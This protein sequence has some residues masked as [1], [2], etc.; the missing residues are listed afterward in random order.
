MFSK[1]IDVAIVYILVCKQNIKSALLYFY[2]CCVVQLFSQK[3]GR[4]TT[5]PTPNKTF[6][7]LLLSKKNY[8]NTRDKC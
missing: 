3:K 7:R 1:S 4:L 2:K 6:K 5:Q 8:F